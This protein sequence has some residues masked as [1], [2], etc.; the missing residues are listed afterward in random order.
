MFEAA[1]IGLKLAK[2]EYRKIEPKL[3]ADLLEAQFALS[4]D[5]RFPVIILISGVR[6][7]GKG[8]TV[9]LLNEWMDPRYIHTYAFDNPSDEE[10]ERPRMWRYWRALPPKG[11]IGILFGAWHT[12]PI[13]NRVLGKTDDAQMEIAM[14][15]VAHFERMLADEGVLLLKFWFHLSKKSQKKRLEALAA[16]AKTSWRV[17]DSDWRRYKLY[18]RFRKISE[19]ALRETSTAYAPWIVVE[20]SDPNYRYLTVGR[21]VLDAMKKRLSGKRIATSRAAALPEPW[22]WK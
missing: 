5:G 12:D 19:R 21:T 20:G 10:R 13:V 11:R 4:K 1:E 8:E 16:D 2:E 22:A 14:E 15:E 18:D 17:T 6:G 9:N 3:R 7:A